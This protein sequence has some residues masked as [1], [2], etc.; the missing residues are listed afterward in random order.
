MSMVTFEE[1]GDVKR[2]ECILLRVGDLVSPES[3]FEGALESKWMKQGFLDALICQLFFPSGIES[4][5]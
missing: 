5:R 4:A 1:C 2:F 3:I